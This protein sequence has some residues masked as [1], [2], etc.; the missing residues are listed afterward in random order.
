[1]GTFNY[2]PSTHTPPAY[3]FVP[4]VPNEF[5][6]D[7]TPC[8]RYPFPDQLFYWSS[9]P[10]GEDSIPPEDWEHYGIPKLTVEMWI[11]SVWASDQYDK[12]GE[13]LESEDYAAD[14]QQYAQD[15]NYPELI[16]GNPH[17]VQIVEDEDS[18]SQ[19]SSEADDS[20]LSSAPASPIPMNPTQAILIDQLDKPVFETVL[21]GHALAE[22]QDDIPMD[23]VAEEIPT[24]LN[25]LEL[26]MSALT[27]NPWADTLPEQ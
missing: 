10:N 1:M 8:I 20:Q 16:R 4:L 24:L 25:D 7:D 19:L 2:D 14:G 15:H 12:V 17:D 26:S 11:G 27:F 23:E 9:D 18:D 22:A 5:L 3:L 21:S 6:P 13:Y